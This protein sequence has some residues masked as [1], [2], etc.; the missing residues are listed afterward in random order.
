MMLFLPT[1]TYRGELMPLRQIP[2]SSVQLVASCLFAVHF[3]AEWSVSAVGVR[4]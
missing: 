4:A 1:R 2:R 3:G